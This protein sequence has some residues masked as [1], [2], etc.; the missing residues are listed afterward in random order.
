MV[1]K[2]KFQ[3]FSFD[4]E[5]LTDPTSANSS[6]STS[7]ISSRGSPEFSLGAEQHCQYT[8][9]SQLTK[10]RV[11]L[12]PPGGTTEAEDEEAAM[13]L[14][15]FHDQDDEAAL[16]PSTRC[17]IKNEDDGSSNSGGGEVIF[18]S[19]SQEVKPE[20]MFTIGFQMLFPFLVAG[21]GMVAAGITLDRVQHWRVFEKV[22]EIFIL[23]PALL[24]L[25]GNLEMTLASRLSTNANKGLL[26]GGSSRKSIIIGNIVLVEAQAMVVAFL[27]SLVA[28]VLGWIPDGT[29][30]TNHAILLCLGS[31][32]TGA[33][34]SFFLGNFSFLLSLST[35]V[36]LL[37]LVSLFKSS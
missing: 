2:A 1:P 5:N 26:D 6:A 3:E 10:G 36:V 22:P 20:T 19:S 28:M 23:V 13:A 15:Y 27:A 35:S 24:G 25:K 8:E 30:E 7:T 31:L 37:L 34:A 17:K 4:E 33:L 14:G 12:K 21:F 16:L 29:W 11:K 9:R 18:I 32:L